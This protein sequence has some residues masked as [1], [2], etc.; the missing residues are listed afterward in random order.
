MVDRISK[1]HRS[2]N[3]GRIRSENTG[4]EQL[5]RAHLHRRG[6]RFRLHGKVS[7]RLHPKGVLPGKPD[8]VLAGYKTVIF[9]HGCFWHRHPGC[10]VTTTPKTRTEW[11]QNKFNG[12]V[13][14]DQ[15]KYLELKQLGWKVLIVW[16][17]ET[18]PG[19]I[20]E[21]IDKLEGGIR[22]E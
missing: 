10:S 12:N 6:F 5:V 11:W 4:P 9:V 20:E 7:K 13:E 1:E 18:K 15:R 8:I 14:R 22:S 19:L 16:G 2:W 3:M 17:C 21:T